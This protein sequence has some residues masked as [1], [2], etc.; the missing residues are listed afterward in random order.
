MH[1][2]PDRPCLRAL[3]QHCLSFR[4][5]PA[6]L[7]SHDD[8]DRMDSLLLG[9]SRRGFGL[10][11]ILTE[12]R[13]RPGLGHSPRRQC[14]ALPEKGLVHPGENHRTGRT[15]PTPPDKK[16]HLRVGS[17]VYLDFEIVPCLC[18]LRPGLLGKE[19][20]FFGKTTFW[21]DE[22][23]SP[24]CIRTNLKGKAVHL[25]DIWSRSQSP[26]NAGT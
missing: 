22:S 11:T 25:G 21:E 24:R 3:P 20:R 8:D 13:G 10:V 17:S 18:P 9:A 6:I 4:L 19:I 26:F 15:P 16:V 5:C 12:E 23:Y 14:G 1:R 2:N 7:L